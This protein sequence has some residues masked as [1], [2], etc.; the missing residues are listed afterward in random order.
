MGSG[1][2]AA[3][4]I[5]VIATIM[6]FAP[7][8]WHLLSMQPVSTKT[9]TKL[10]TVTTTIATP[11]PLTVERT[12]FVTI[13][14]PMLVTVTTPMPITVTKSIFKTLPTTITRTVTTTRIYPVTHSFATTIVSTKRLTTTRTITVTTT[15][16]IIITSTSYVWATITATEIVK[17]VQTKT[18]TTTTTVTRIR[19][20]F[21][22]R[23]VDWSYVHNI[24]RSGRVREIY[25]VILYS[26]GFVGMDPSFKQ[27]ID[28]LEWL[29]S[30]NVSVKVLVHPRICY[31]F[32]PYAPPGAIAPELVKI[33][34]QLNKT[35]GFER[36]RAI[37]PRKLGPASTIDWLAPLGSTDGLISV[38][39]LVILDDG[40]ALYFE[41]V[42]Y[43][44]KAVIVDHLEKITYTLSNG[45]S[46]NLKNWMKGAFNDKFEHDSVVWN[47]DKVCR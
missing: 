17:E 36:L 15:S 38:E 34:N 5:A 7:F 21:N 25:V 23:I 33:V 4:T 39:A 12:S 43:T 20:L 29:I 32:W 19:T 41:L 42:A 16:P 37:D 6:V 18:I 45:Y 26:G 14:K 31:W 3:I 11:S 2:A 40:S 13:T 46:S 28:D 8:I 44:N 24:L 27:F 22:L 10:E 35:L 47:P 1:T 30:K 9:L